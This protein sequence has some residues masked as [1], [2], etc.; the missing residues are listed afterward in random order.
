MAVGELGATITSSDG[1]TWNTNPV[2]V[3]KYLNRI[4]YNGY[5]YV[6]V[7][8]DGALISSDNGYDWFAQNTE[9]NN[10]LRG[11]VWTGTH[12]I[13]VS[14]RGGYSSKSVILKSTDGFIWDISFFG[15]PEKNL[16]ALAWANNK[17]IAVGNIGF[18]DSNAYISSDGVTWSVIDMIEGNYSNVYWDGKNFIA[19]GEG[20]FNISADGVNWQPKALP[21]R[22]DLYLS[23][24][25]VSWSGRVY[26]TAMFSGYIGTSSNVTDWQK[27]DPGARQYLLSSASSDLIHVVGGNWGDIYTSEDGSNW[28]LRITGTEM[29]ILSIV[30]T[31]DRFVAVGKGS[32]I[33]DDMNILT[34]ADGISWIMR[35][36]GTA[37]AL[38]DVIWTGSKLVAVGDN[39]TIIMSEQTFNTLNRSYPLVNLCKI[40]TPIFDIEINIS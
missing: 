16:T 21:G 37:N 30:W 29:K 11:I 8:D 24:F 32:H 27:H 14:G 17:F 38:N 25:R 1:H 33:N 3:E 6:A 23:L 9:V 7:G 28:T 22:Y 26:V 19:S 35:Q 36:S 20:V 40:L 18:S 2:A 13:V 10:D 39:G 31:G 34:S 15:F 12:F 5:L 4:I